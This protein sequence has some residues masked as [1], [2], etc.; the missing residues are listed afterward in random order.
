MCNAKQQHHFQAWN[1]RTWHL[2]DVWRK[3]TC[4]CTWTLQMSSG[5]IKKKKKILGKTC[6]CGYEWQTIFSFVDREQDWMLCCSDRVIGLLG[7]IGFKRKPTHRMMVTD[8]GVNATGIF[9]S[10]HIQWKTL[11][12]CFNHCTMSWK[13]GPPFKW[14]DSGIITRLTITQNKRFI[15]I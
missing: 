2:F 12:V 3:Q 9:F 8:K 7:E 14:S 6:L 5:Q 4:L 11:G 13:M 15:F 10:E 1:Q